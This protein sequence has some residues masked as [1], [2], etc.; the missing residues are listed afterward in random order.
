MPFSAYPQPLKHLPPHSKC[1]RIAAINH[2]AS[3]HGRTQAKIRRAACMSCLL[4]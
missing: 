1:T 2:G 3:D 4:T